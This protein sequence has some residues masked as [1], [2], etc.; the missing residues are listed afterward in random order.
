ML[1][2]F[3]VNIEGMVDFFDNGLRLISDEQKTDVLKFYKEA[4]R[5][6]KI[7]SILLLKYLVNKFIEKKDFKILVLSFGKPY[8]PKYPEFQFN[9]S[10]AGSWVVAVVSNLPVGIDVEEIRYVKDFIDIAKTFFSKDEMLAIEQQKVTEKQLN[11]FYEFWTQKES[12]I[13]AV[14]RGL[15]IPL[16]SF[17]VLSKKSGDSIE[18]D[19]K[20]WFIY[21]PKFIDKKYKLSVCLSEKVN[22]DSSLE[23]KYLKIAD[24]LE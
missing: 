4:D 5:H 19:G 8:L 16:N 7:I 22:R 13:K 24:L 2:L 20:Q 23:I 11:L 9:L 17:S 10:H 6:R 12:L 3:A 14:G 21:M 1:A 18:Y 15:S